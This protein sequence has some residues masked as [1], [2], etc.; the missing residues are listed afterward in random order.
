[1]QKKLC[2]NVAFRLRHAYKQSLKS[3]CLKVSSC[4]ILSMLSAK[5]NLVQACLAPHKNDKN[6]LLALKNG[7]DLCAV[8]T[9]ELLAETARTAAAHGSYDNLRVAA[10]HYCITRLAKPLEC[11]LLRQA[12]ADMR[13]SP[14]HYPYLHQVIATINH[15]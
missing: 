12:I 4:S 13:K 10:T 2:S 5:D 15:L 8:I 3:Y 9:P 6:I 14:D 7:R 11:A 1:M